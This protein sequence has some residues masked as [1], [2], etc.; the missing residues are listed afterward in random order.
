MLPM[1]HGGLLPPCEDGRVPCVRCGRKFNADRIAKHQFVCTSL[2]NMETA[3]VQEPKERRVETVQT[4]AS[5]LAAARV[6][7]C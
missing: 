4:A 3:R 6:E 5:M 7:A 2:K 1:Q